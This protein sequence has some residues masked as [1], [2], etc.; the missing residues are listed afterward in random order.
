M[1]PKEAKGKPSENG[2]LEV[3][4]QV[5]KDLQDQI[6]D[7]REKKDSDGGARRLIA[8]NMYNT[9]HDRLREYSNIS[10]SAVEPFSLAG[11]CGSVFDADVLSGKKSLCQVYLENVLTYRRAVGGQL[12]KF[13]AEQAKEEAQ[14]T[15]ES[16]GEEAQLGQGM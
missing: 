15:R 1:I 2:H 5:V 8:D 6:N 13:A 3:I 11:T 10:N 9:P 12:G 16:L 4:L 7:L 14:Q